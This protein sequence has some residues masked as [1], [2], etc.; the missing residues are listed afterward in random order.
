MIIFDILR[1]CAALMVFSIHL[2]IFIPELPR[3]VCDILSNGGYGVSVFFVISGFLIFESLNKSRTLKEYYIKRISRIIPAYYAILIVGILVWDIGLKQMPVDSY[4]HIGW[5]RYFLCLN[6]WLPSGDYNYWNNLWGLWTISCFVFFYLI[7][8]L[9]KKYINNFMKSAVFMVVMIPA[10]FAF[11]K[12][13]EVFFAGVSAS[14]PEMLACDNPVY[15]LNTFAMGICAWYAW[16]EDRVKDFLKI[17]V[18]LL[19]GFI[20][21]NMYNRMLWGML[22]AIIMMV[23]IDLDIKNKLVVNIIKIMGRYSFCLYLMHLPVIE[24]IDYYGITGGKYLLIATISSILAAV[25]LYHCV[26]R[27]CSGLLRKLGER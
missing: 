15:S 10:T 16:K 26:E 21:L 6:T 18:L 3:A 2:F 7:A 13:A 17:A 1:I 12:I 9:L 22:T 27:P 14:L 5:L 20:G 11:S 24:V 25:L 8:P 4:A 23:F 19:T